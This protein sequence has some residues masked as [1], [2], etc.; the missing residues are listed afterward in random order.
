[1]KIFTPYGEK[2]PRRAANPGSGMEPHYVQRY[3]ETGHP[4]LIKD[5]ETDVYAIIQSHKD[6]C[7]INVLL[8]KYTG[9]DMTVLHQGGTYADIA[10]L[11]ENMHEMVNF[12]NAQRERFEALPA[13]IK[14]KFENSF[15]V[16]AMAAGTNDWMEKMNIRQVAQTAKQDP[17]EQ[18]VQN[19]KGGE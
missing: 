14:Q 3:D 17:K 11:P 7:D 4:Y 8:Q 10:D 1:M 15:E 19:D 13:A 2:P 18:I 16:W 12:V 5:G 6:E 9:G